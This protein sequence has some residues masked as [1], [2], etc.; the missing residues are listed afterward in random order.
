MCKALPWERHVRAVLHTQEETQES[1]GLLAEGAVRPQGCPKRL[2]FAACTTQR[3]QVQEGVGFELCVTPAAPELWVD[4]DE[5]ML[6]QIVTNLVQNA[7]R[8]TTTGRIKLR[9]EVQP[10]PDDP[11]PFA[12][13]RFVVQAR[14]N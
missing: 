14:L 12:L 7:C 4:S 5:T 3:A 11:E 10:L 8:F 13:V 6:L 1:R 9:C 2:P